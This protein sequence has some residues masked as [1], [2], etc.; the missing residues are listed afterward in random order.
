MTEVVIATVLL[1]SAYL[2]S[3]QKKK[4][5]FEQQIEKP[6][7]TNVLQNRMEQTSL[8][9]KR[10]PLVTSADK[11]FN[12][13]TKNDSSF[14]H[15]NMTPFY[16]NN[17]YGTNNFVN[18]NRLDTYTGSGSNT[19]V[20]QETATLFKP[21]DNLQ[22]VFGN[23]N[24]NDFLQSRVNESRRH[25]NS[26][27]WEEIRE[28][29]GDLGFN[30]S[31]QYRDQTQP[32]NVDQLRTS[33]NPKSVYNLNYKSPAYK[34]NQSG[35]I[36]TIGK[37]IKK[38]PDTY[39]MNEGC[40]GV[41]P[42]RGIEQSTQKPL[43][44][45]T[46]EN[47]E[48]TSVLYYG[49]RGNN[50]T[51]SYTTSNNE[52]SK[53]QQLPT[54][55]FTNLSSNGIF[56]VSDHGKGSFQLLENNRTTKQDYFGNITGQ[57][58]SNVISP[59]TN[60]F[61]QEKKVV[62]H[63]N[64]SGFMS[65]TSKKPMTNPYQS[66]PTTNREMTSESKGHLNV[67]GQS[68]NIYIHSNPYMNHTQRQSTSHSIMGG[69]NGTSQFKSYDA[70]Y[71]QRNIQKPYENRTANGNMKLYNG[72]IN[73]SINGHEQYNTRTN[74]L[75]IPKSDSIMG[76]MTKQNQS[77]ELP[78]MDNSILKAFKENPYTHSLSSVA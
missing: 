57:F 70:E 72:G 38:T 69:A 55:P 9:P 30:S 56:Q 17:S 23:Q 24:Q 61:K 29:P 4:E 76:E 63:P 49:V 59:I 48:N 25:A 12:K 40:G 1:G 3:N 21:Q 46:N 20:K 47:R 16:K 39:H 36:G 8:N 73:A 68:S 41:G 15:N 28:G 45:L 42:A 33:N 71:N 27:P 11:H 14:T 60:H 62:E 67:Q 58:I 74:A 31:M 6:T 19:I 2:V 37:V 26:K 75:Y 7:I 50:S 54:Q 32:K 44:M 51:T 5:N 43:Q 66:T 78:A 35:N 34:P 22:N 77:Y 53:K 18:D 64:Q 65:I 52:Q 10:E 13:E